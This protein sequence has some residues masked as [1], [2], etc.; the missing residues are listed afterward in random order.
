MARIRS[1]KPDFWLNEELSAIHPESC[2]LAIGLLNISD[3]EGYFN[4]NER[5]IM[6]GVFPLREL[7]M[8]VQQMLNELSNIGYIELF[9]AEDGKKYGH[10]KK[11]TSHQVINRPTASKIKDLHRISDYSVSAHGLITDDSSGKGKERKGRSSSS[12]DERFNDFWVAFADSRGKAGAERVW[13]RIKPDEQLAEK[14]IA[15]ARRYV[16]ARGTDGKYW[17]QAQGWLNDR[18]WEDEIEPVL[19]LVNDTFAGSL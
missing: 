9:I 19:A 3:D 6:A 15:G 8:S 18:R 4:A 1:I 11:F 12:V 5:L 16:K 10:I 2:L 13:K 17:K 14:I 7:S